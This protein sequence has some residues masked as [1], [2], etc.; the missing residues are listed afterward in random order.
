MVSGTQDILSGSLINRIQICTGYCFSNARILFTL[1]VF[2]FRL[3]YAVRLN[4]CI[5]RTLK[6]NMYI[7]EI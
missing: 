4:T 5:N 2:R 3:M 6:P 7:N 1:S